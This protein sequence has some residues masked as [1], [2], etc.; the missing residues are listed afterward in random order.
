MSNKVRA[1]FI[2]D[3][4][5]K[6]H[7]K[8]SVCI[9]GISVGQE[10]HEGIKFKATIDLVG[11]HFKSCVIAVCDS[12]Q[13]HTLKIGTSLTDQEA[14]K[15]ANQAGYEWINRNIGYINNLKIPYDLFRWDEWLLHENYALYKQEILDLYAN[16]TIFKRSMDITIDNFEARFT[17]NKLT[18]ECIRNASFKY[19][20]EECAVSMLG[21]SK[22]AYNYIVYPSD[23]IEVMREAH[24]RFAR[25]PGF[26]ILEWV[27]IKLKTKYAA[28]SLACV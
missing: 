3:L 12:L 9:L 25:T 24:L 8:D 21:W 16:D 15:Q 10:A 22:K 5:K 17:R 28:D 18:A 20:V 14:H 26:D 27:R 19:L 23:M 7:F 13:R 4:E 1:R 11:K 6:S 2:C